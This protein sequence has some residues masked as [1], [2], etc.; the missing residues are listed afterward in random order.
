MIEPINENLA[1]I[2]VLAHSTSRL[3]GSSETG[4]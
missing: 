1:T 2:V 4:A 3:P